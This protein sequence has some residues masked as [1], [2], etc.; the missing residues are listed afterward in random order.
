MDARQKALLD[1]AN[2]EHSPVREFEDY[3][4]PPNFYNPWE[5]YGETSM[6]YGVPP[7]N[8]FGGDDEDTEVEESPPA[9]HGGGG[10]GD[11]DDE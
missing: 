11:D 5:E 10:N 7:P 9:A 4:P 6:M 2:I 8:I 3:P 1:Q